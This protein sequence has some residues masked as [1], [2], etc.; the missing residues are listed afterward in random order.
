MKSKGKAL[1]SGPQA[2]KGGCEMA[3]M[4]LGD[5][6][7]GSHGCRDNWGSTLG[8]RRD[9]PLRF[10]EPSLASWEPSLES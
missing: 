5:G 10:P 8:N 7:Y 1:R 9:R 2:P 4:A 6:K 3:G